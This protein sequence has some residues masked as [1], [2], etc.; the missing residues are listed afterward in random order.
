V[1]VITGWK[2]VPGVKTMYNL[3]VA[4]DHTFVVGVGQWVVH[5]CTTPEGASYWFNDTAIHKNGQTIIEEMQAR[6]WD[7]ESVEQALDK[8]SGTVSTFDNRPGPTRGDPATGFYHPDG[9]GYVVQNN[10]TGEIFS[11]SDRNDKGWLPFWRP[12]DI[13]WR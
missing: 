13:H 4:Q 2:V 8:P 5:N 12:E 11:V 10:N 9:S 6:G 1:G 3:E 7:T